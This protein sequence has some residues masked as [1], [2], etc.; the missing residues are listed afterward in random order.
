MQT[1]TAVDPIFAPIVGCFT[2]DVAT[3]ILEIRLDDATQKRM[4]QWARQANE[5]QLA[6][7]DRAEYE[8][9]INK[10]DTLALFKSL[11]RQALKVNA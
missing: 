5:G 6:D 7:S 2:H 3:R 9:L 1:F 11:A 8:R 10:L 4:D